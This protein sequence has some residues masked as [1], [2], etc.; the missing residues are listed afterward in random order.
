MVINM[1]LSFLELIIKFIKNK[2]YKCVK[3]SMHDKTIT[4]LAN[5]FALKVDITF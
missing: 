3:K 5:L 1:M 2:V 4:D